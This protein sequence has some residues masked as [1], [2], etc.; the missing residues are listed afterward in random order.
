MLSMFDL[1][2]EDQEAIKQKFRSYVEMP[3]GEQ[4]P[5]IWVG[6]RKT[7]GY[8]RLSFRSRKYLAHRL[9]WEIANG[10]IPDG[11]NVL[12][13]FDDPPN[14]NPSHLFL[15]TQKDNMHDASVK[16]RI[17]AHKGEKSGMAKLTDD[18]VKEIRDLAKSGYTHRQIGKMYGVSH[19]TA[20]SAISGRSW[21]HV[22]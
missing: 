5:W 9:S 13:K 18:L 10:P 19:A 2:K 16:G 11:N 17:V 12:H 1:P 8:G 21:G 6:L 14:V 22:L 3:E 7:G 4:G 15:G 20:G